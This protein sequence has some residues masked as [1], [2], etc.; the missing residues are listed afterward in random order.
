MFPAQNAIGIN[1]YKNRRKY[2]MNFAQTLSK[3][4]DVIPLFFI[5]ST[6]MV[7]SLIS[8][9]HKII[10]ETIVLNKPDIFNIDQDPQYAGND[11]TG[12][13]RQHQN[14]ISIDGKRPLYG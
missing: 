7:L 5:R 12:V 4:K 8:D 9:L 1:T 11:F 10:T 2:K 13:L 3:I 6:D 14:R